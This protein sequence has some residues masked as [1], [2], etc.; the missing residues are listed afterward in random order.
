MDVQSIMYTKN[1]LIIPF[2]SCAQSHAIRPTSRKLNLFHTLYNNNAW[3]DNV[4]TMW[5]CERNHLTSRNMTSIEQH[6]RSELL[7]TNHLSAYK[8]VI[9]IENVMMRQ[10]HARKWAKICYCNFMYRNHLQSQQWRKLMKTANL[11]SLYQWMSFFP[12]MKYWRVKMAGRQEPDSFV[13]ARKKRNW[14]LCRSHRFSQTFN[15]LSKDVVNLL[16][17][18]KSPAKCFFGMHAHM[19]IPS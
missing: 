9:S 6:C 4:K 2:S 8:F 10:W 5:R 19:N 18:T 16:M 11:V 14:L 7:Q 17:G 1:N 15:G 13:I 12:H 3:N